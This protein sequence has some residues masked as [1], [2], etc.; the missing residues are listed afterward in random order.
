MFY[1]RLL[2]NLQSVFVKNYLKLKQCI[3]WH[4]FFRQTKGLYYRP[5]RSLGQGNIFTRVCHSVHRGGS[6]S[7]LGR[8]PPQQ[9]PPPL[10]DTPRADTPGADT[11][12]GRP[13]LADTP[14]DRHSPLADTPP[15]AYSGIQSTTRGRYASYWNAFLLRFNTKAIF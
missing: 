1:K 4:S 5:Q 2:L 12:P 9:T 15:R 6:A 11:P 14:P 10:A 13:P 8:H 3:S 7:G